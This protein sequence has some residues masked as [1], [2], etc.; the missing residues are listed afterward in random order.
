MLI[1]P[2]LAA[3]AFIRTTPMVMKLDIDNG[4]VISKPRT[5]KVRV[6]VSSEVLITQV[7]MYVADDLRD[8]ATSTP[9]TFKIDPLAEKDGDLKLTFTAYSSEGDKTSKSVNVTIDT[10]AS[11]GVDYNTQQAQQFLIES[12]WDD[13]IMSARVAL[14]VQPDYNPARLVIARAF[15]RKGVYD[16]AQQFTENVLSS[17]PNNPAALELISAIHLERAFDSYA[18]MGDKTNVLTTMADA[19]KTAIDSRRK[20]LDADFDKLPAP[21][22]E[23][24]I[25]YADVA[26]R[27]SHFSAVISELTPQFN[28]NWKATYGDRIGYAQLR[29]SRFTDLTHTLVLMRD[30]K[31]LDAYGYALAAVLDEYRGDKDQADEDIKSAIEENSQ[32]VGVQT[33]QTY[34]AVHRNN[35]TVLTSLIA[36]LSDESGHLPE[37]NYYRSVLYSRMQ[38]F[39]DSDK[40]F[41]ESVLTEPLNYQMYIERGNESLA[42]VASGKIKDPQQSL[43]AYFVGT[44]MFEAALE[45][46][47][48]SAEALTALTIV[49]IFQNHPAKAVDFAE[50]AIKAAPDY[51]P[52]HYAAA[53]VYANTQQKLLSD[54]DQIRQN[55]GGAMDEDMVKKVNYDK[56]QAEGA[57]RRANEE[58]ELA[59]KCDPKRLGGRSLPIPM[60]VFN[61]FYL[62][63]QLPFLPAPRT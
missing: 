7:E 8:S 51:A 25:H 36:N 23:N 55:S 56:T 18:G 3:L 21:T 45:A 58:L 41:R 2:F 35:L 46:K 61:Y 37:V 15:L 54:A 52:G 27:T 17:D 28:V 12:K 42:R 9:Y 32:D 59:S 24:Q 30:K 43:Y 11:K 38:Q 40:A 39:E 16:K 31:T 1:A 13:A 33:A 48:D 10:G 53:E 57:A 49:N 29:L 14:K 62:N 63:G 22:T 60:D 6:Q 47:P 34:I 50:A 5:I 26:L 20:F 44:K 19:I 4:E